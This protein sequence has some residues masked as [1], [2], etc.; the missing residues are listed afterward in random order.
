MRFMLLMIPKGYE[1]APPDEPPG[2]AEAVAAT[3]KYI[4]DMH[5]AGVLLSC[6]GL[7]PPSAGARVTFVGGAPKVTDGPFAEAKETLGGFWMIDVKSK[8]E[9]VAWATCCPAGENG[10]IEVRRVHEFEDFPADL[11]QEINDRHEMETK[12]AV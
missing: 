9:A 8:E 12:A 10:L 2:T 3:R 5:E 4:S 1:S 6:E 11:Q 7:H